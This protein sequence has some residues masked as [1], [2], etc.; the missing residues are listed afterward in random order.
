MIIELTD[1]T[2]KIYPS[3]VAI[4]TFGSNVQLSPYVITDVADIVYGLYIIRN[5]AGVVVTG[6]VLSLQ[7]GAY[8]G[9]L[10]TFPT[11]T[12]TLYV[13]FQDVN[14]VS[15]EERSMV[16]SVVPFNI[17]SIIEQVMPIM[18]ITMAFG[19]I[20]PMM[21]NMLRLSNK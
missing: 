19:M 3:G 13:V 10:K 18:M 4:Q 21:K 15:L 6:G 9:T 17:N 11:D 20:M 5:S 16:F 12:Y 1:Q 7:N 14:E 2:G 8:V